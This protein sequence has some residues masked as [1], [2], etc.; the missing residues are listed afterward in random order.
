MTIDVRRGRCGRVFVRLHGTFDA[1]AA[2]AVHELLQAL[3]PARG[4]I[5][6]FHAIR[7]VEP[8]ALAALAGETSAPARRLTIVGMSRRSQRLL[9]DF[10]RNR[11]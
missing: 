1:H 3:D 11:N 5:L 6:D 8:W 4:V 9:N 10:A 2:D 7:S